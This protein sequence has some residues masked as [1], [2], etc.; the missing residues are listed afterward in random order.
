MLGV[1]GYLVGEAG[2][3]RFLQR[4]FNTTLMRFLPR[5]LGRVYLGL[6]GKIY[7]LFNQA[8]KEQLK[9]NLTAVIRR[10]P[11]REP[12]D[13]VVRRTFRGIFAHYHEKL[14]T[15]HG[16]Y[17]KVSKFIH[18]QVKWTGQN[19]LEEALSQG[20]GLILV[21]GHFG[22]VEFLPTFLA[23]KGYTVTMV[24]RF[25][26]ARLKRTL[27]LRAARLGITLLDANEN[28]GVI[29]SALK[30]LK[31]N[32]ILIT[33][34]DE[35]ESWR[36][37]RN[38]SIQFLGCSSPLDRTLDLIQR[39][40]DSPAIMGLVYRGQK[41][42]YALQ[43]HSLNGTCHGAETAN[44]AQKALRILEQYIYIAPHQWYQWK[45]LRIILG[46]NLFEETGPIHAFEADQSASIADS[47][48]H[49]C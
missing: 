39:R 42:R 14:Y 38:R 15:A 43:L 20:R 49:A 12:T 41:N 27:N 1:P 40:Y 18:K 24:V 2:L 37:Y 31:S 4:G 8:E 28:E 5:K 36:P 29:F 17:D 21:T 22:A 13:K 32:Q 45:G 30:A 46:T 48:L 6:L 9:Q 19:L 10:L 3:S 33:E 11:N 23:L 44:I 47:A 16:N 25:K 26:T 34:C 7:Y 35:F